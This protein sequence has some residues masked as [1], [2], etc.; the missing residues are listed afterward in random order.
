MAL[1]MQ[2]RTLA[3]SAIGSIAETQEMLDFCAEHGIAAEI[4]VISTAQVNEALG[5]RPEVRRALPL[6]HRQLDALNR[7]R[8]RLRSPAFAA[9]PAPRADTRAAACAATE[10]APS[11]PRPSTPSQMGVT[12]LH[13]ADRRHGARWPEPPLVGQLHARVDREVPQLAGEV[14]DLRVAG[15]NA[16]RVAPHPRAVAGAPDAPLLRQCPGWRPP[17]L[18][19]PA[20]C[21]RSPSLRTWVRIAVVR[22]ERCAEWDATSAFQQDQRRVH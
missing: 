22:P 8:L 17:L 15:H 4:E 6:R 12:P 10:S 18:G 13:C 20:T 3:G 9:G 7:H 21:R 16:D 11:A 2:R 14:H 5:A 1:I 19:R